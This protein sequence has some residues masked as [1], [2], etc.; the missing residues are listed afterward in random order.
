MLVTPLPIVTLVKL[1]HWLNVNSPMFVTESGI[2]IFVML[3]FEN[4]PFPTL[5]TLSGIVTPDR[6]VQP[7]NALDPMLV[8]AGPSSTVWGSFIQDD[9]LYSPASII[10][11]WVISPDQLYFCEV[12]SVNVIRVDVP[13]TILMSD[14]LALANSSRA[15]VVVLPSTTMLVRRLH[16][17]NTYMPILITL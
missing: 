17:E 12:P 3:V 7:R 13:V 5:V 4:T 9:P 6:L 10:V 8:T 2:V 16:P 14:R 15:S 11:C 1:L